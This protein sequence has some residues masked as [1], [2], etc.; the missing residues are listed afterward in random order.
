MSLS[1]GCWF[2]A[3]AGCGEQLCPL[4]NKNYYVRFYGGVGQR[5]GEL[6]SAAVGV[7][8][9]LTSSRCAVG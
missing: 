3:G 5:W 8:A 9:L 2:T 4:M 7:V 6:L 1:P